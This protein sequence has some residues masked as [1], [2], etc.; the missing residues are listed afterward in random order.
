[1]VIDEFQHAAAATYRQVIAHFAPR[2]L[3]GL[4]AIPERMDGADLLGLCGDNLVFD[5]D[6]VTG[7]RQGNLVPFDYFGV[8]DVTDF[9]PTP[10]RNG[11]F[12]PEALT[13][14]VETRE[15]AQQA[16]DEWRSRG[17]GRTLAFCC[18]ITHA[19]Y[20]KA[21]TCPAWTAC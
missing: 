13:R 11:R 10:W 4:T 16:L 17:A 12:D 8:R 6:L 1:V 19:D 3:L 5:C 20:M 21:S 7:I 14:A 18:S 15:R 9:E 2:F